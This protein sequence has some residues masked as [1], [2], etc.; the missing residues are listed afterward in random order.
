MP[1][2]NNNGMLCRCTLLSKALDALTPINTP[3]YTKGLLLWHLPTCIVPRS[4]ADSSKHV[5]TK[6]KDRHASTRDTACNTF[7]LSVL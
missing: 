4:S 7:R 3:N 5:P 2:T 6:S 1:L